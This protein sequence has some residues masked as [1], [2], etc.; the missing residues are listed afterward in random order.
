MAISPSVLSFF[1]R[2][3]SA[4]GAWA[5]G[6]E[7]AKR[8]SDQRVVPKKPPTPPPAEAATP[9][10]PTPPPVNASAPVVP[11][12]P[13]PTAVA[14]PPNAPQAAPRDPSPQRPSPSLTLPRVILPSKLQA[15][16][17]SSDKTLYSFSGFVPTAPPIPEPVKPA[18][19]I[20]EPQLTQA[21]ASQPPPSY[22]ES[23]QS[24]GNEYGYPPAPQQHHRG[25]HH[26]AGHGGGH[27]PFDYASYQ[28]SYGS[29]GWD[30]QQY[31]YGYGHPGYYQPAPNNRPGRGMSRGTDGRGGEFR[32]SHLFSRQPPQHYNNFQQPMQYG[33]NPGAQPYYPP[34][35]YPG[36]GNYQAGYN[37]GG[38]RYHR[39]QH[40]QY[41][42][43]GGQPP[44]PQGVDE[45][46]Q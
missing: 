9:P 41:P 7:L 20:P 15:M 21:P 4:K 35:Y 31:G 14:E 25:R 29:G 44:P 11:T 46:Y 43:Q 18:P 33:Q 28:P 38:A 13:S 30:T 23:T 2:T 5:A 45:S 34:N 32:P 12:P 8:L 26:H 36:G 42:P 22:G 16:V 6:G 19:Q 37:N 27:V 24:V 3:M 17:D 39:Q 10:P 40:P 1:A